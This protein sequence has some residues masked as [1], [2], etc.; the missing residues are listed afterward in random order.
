L[1]SV[2][3]CKA[4]DEAGHPSSISS[5][6]KHTEL[7]QENSFLTQRLLSPE[8]MHLHIHLHLIFL[9]QTFPYIFTNESTS[10]LLH[11]KSLQSG[12]KAIAWSPSTIPIRDC[13]SSISMLV[14]EGD[15]RRRD[16]RRW[17]GAVMAG[18][19]RGSRRFAG[20][21]SSSHVSQVSSVF[22]EW[23]VSLL[24]SVCVS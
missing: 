8:N 22:T 17:R 2:S 3:K 9:T 19:E 24:I 15:T 16:R 7:S 10:S 23:W 12:P 6:V 18:A 5:H 4:L 11:P 14:V 13:A 20:R 1:E 21:G